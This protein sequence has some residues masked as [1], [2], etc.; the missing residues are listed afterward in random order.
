MGDAGLEVVHEAADRVGELGPA[1]GDDAVGQLTGDLA[2]RRLVGGGG[3][4]LNSGHKSFGTL[5]A[6][7]RIRC[8]R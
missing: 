6:R 4:A 2:A 8:A 1:V 7:L 3:P 5:A